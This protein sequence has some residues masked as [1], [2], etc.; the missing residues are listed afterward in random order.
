MQQHDLLHELPEHK[1]R[2]HELKVSSNHFRRLFDKY[3]E[4]ND[5]IHRIEVGVENTK[6]EVL[7]QLRRER[8]HLK[9]ELLAIIT[10]QD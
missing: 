1:E 5:E 9:D 10:S 6:D 2:I 3:H 4:V 7:N 8:L